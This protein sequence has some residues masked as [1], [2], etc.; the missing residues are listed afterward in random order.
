MFVGWCHAIC[1]TIHSVQNLSWCWFWAA[2]WVEIKSL[3]CPFACCFCFLFLNQV[4]SGLGFLFYPF[5]FIVLLNTMYSLFI[6]VNEISLLGQNHKDVVNILKELPI[7]VTMVCCRPVAPPITHP[8]VLES[9]S[10]SEVQ[11]TEKVF[12]LKK[13]AE[14]MTFY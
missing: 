6:E 14:K 5:L 11:L 10:L 3:Q 9:L 1:E 7:K 8:E 13:I 4:I 12:C 2:N